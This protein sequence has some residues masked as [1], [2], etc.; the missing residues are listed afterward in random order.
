MWCI[1]PGSFPGNFTLQ[2]SLWYLSYSVNNYLIEYYDYIIYTKLNILLL[3][4]NY[5]KLDLMLPLPIQHLSI[6][7]DDD[8]DN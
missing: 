8:D 6:A 7:Y 3:F 1:L 2:L 5:F 4:I